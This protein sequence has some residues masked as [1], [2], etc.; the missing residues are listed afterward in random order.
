MLL[1]DEPSASPKHKFKWADVGSG[2]G[3]NIVPKLDAG[4]EG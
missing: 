2:M 1:N 4:K 3:S